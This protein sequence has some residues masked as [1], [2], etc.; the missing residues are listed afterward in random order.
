MID[1]D[2]ILEGTGAKIRHIKIKTLNDLKN[3]KLHK[4]VQKAIKDRKSK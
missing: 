1:S 3:P 4:L 2:G